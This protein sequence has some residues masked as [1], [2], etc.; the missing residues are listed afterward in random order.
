M[1]GSN[2]RGAGQ[3]DRAT[4]QSQGHVSFGLVQRYRV[5]GPEGLRWGAK[6]DLSLPGCPRESRAAEAP[7]DAL[8]GLGGSFWLRAL[9]M[10]PTSVCE[11]EWDRPSK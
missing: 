5:R 11:L 1:P 8:T 6:A 2:S 9:W 10:L 4:R 3:G 7:P